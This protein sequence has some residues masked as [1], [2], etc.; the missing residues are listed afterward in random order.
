MALDN[1]YVGFIVGLKVYEIFDN[2]VVY[3][4]QVAHCLD[5]NYQDFVYV[6]MSNVDS[7]D[8]IHNTNCPQCK[9]ER[10]RMTTYD[11]SPMER[12]E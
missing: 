10:I 5:C 8:M 6:I 2:G 11:N 4:L 3:V 9:G 12:G 7:E 1:D